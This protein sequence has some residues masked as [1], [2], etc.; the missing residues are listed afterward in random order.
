MA[1]MCFLAFIFAGASEVNAQTDQKTNHIQIEAATSDGASP[2]GFRFSVEGILKGN[3]DLGLDEIIK[4]AAPKPKLSESQTIGEWKTDADG[5]AVIKK[6]NE[7]A[8]KG[9]ACSET[10]PD[11]YAYSLKLKA[12]VTETE[13]KT[14]SDAVLTKKGASLRNAVP[15]ARKAG[16]KASTFLAAAEDDDDDDDEEIDEETPIDIKYVWETAPSPAPKL[17]NNLDED[18]ELV[19]WYA[20][21]FYTVGLDEYDEL[22]YSG[23]ATPGAQA[24]V[25]TDENGEEWRF[26]GWKMSPD[27]EYLPNEYELELIGNVTFYGVWEKTSAPAEPQPA[28]PTE[29]TPL[30]TYKITTEVSGGT[31]TPSMDGLSADSDHSVTYK[32]NDGYVLKSVTVDGTNVDFNATPDFKN[33]YL[34]HIVAEDHSIKVV[35]EPAPKTYKITTEVVGG[36]ITPSM[37]GLSAKSDHS[38]TYKA[39]DGY[40]LKSVTVDGANV[41][42]NATPD[43]RNGYRFHIEAENHS[44]KV[45]YEPAPKPEIETRTYDI[46]IPVTIRLVPAN[47][48]DA[49]SAKTETVNGIEVAYN[50]ISFAGSA[51]S[52]PVEGSTD[53]NGMLRVENVGT[54]HFVVTELLTDGQD[55]RYF[56]PAKQEVD[57]T[58][59]ETQPIVLKFVNEAR[60]IPVK[61]KAAAKKGKTSGVEFQLVGTPDIEGGGEVT[62][63]AKTN[64]DGIADFGLVYPGTYR[65]VEVGSDTASFKAAAAEDETATEP[66]FTI[67][68]DVFTLEELKGGACLWL[69]QSPEGY[70]RSLDGSISAEYVITTADADEDAAEHGVVDEDTA[71]SKGG[72]GNDG[73]K[74]GGTSPGTGESA[75]PLL[76]AG[77][78]AA[79]SLI[80]AL[81]KIVFSR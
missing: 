37:E 79:L 48:K 3:K 55:K 43:F 34:F 80:I 54:G 20:E 68:K 70:K 42:F 47:G 41:D 27:G 81:R 12:T 72:S 71:A 15:S 76:I 31:I 2:S 69:D 57:V 52:E 33:G 51:F 14:V 5:E 23:S 29:P 59:E 9:Y 26:V 30:K 17:P 39:N 7:D 49:V 18:G 60:Q 67:P 19:E 53:E 22:M 11:K 8:K 16:S 40:I 74:A 73:N 75:L 46:E 10:E 56:A 65:T 61:L 35:Y 78:L 66:S 62:L 38:V 4:L 45:V 36:T 25:V 1:I 63:S 13:I 6:I 21:E 28:E 44:I 64:K 77:L 50:D 24:T 32:A 58:G